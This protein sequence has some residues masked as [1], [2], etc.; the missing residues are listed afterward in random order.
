MKYVLMFVET[1][2]FA[3][4]LAAMDDAERGRAYGRVG[5]PVVRRTHGRHRPPH[6]PAATGHRDDSLRLDG[7][8][9]A[10]TDGPF[11]EGKE[12]SAGSPRSTCP[13][14]TRH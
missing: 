4:D 14:S 1:E 13:T 11:V 6:L 12:V 2:Q 8:E 3:A 9:P 7:A 5:R 10:V